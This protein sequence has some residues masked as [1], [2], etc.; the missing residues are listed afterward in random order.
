[1]NFEDSARGELV[2][3]EEQVEAIRAI[4]AAVPELV[5]NARV[6]VFLTGGDDVDEA[7]RRA[8][9]YLEAGADCTYP[10]SETPEP[11]AELTRRIDGPVNVVL[12][13]GI[14]HPRELEKL[15]VARV[16]W[17]GRLAAYA[18]AEAERIAADGL[19]S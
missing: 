12:E 7:V 13:D 16:T 3:L 5:L 17:G 4:K 1:M 11:I 19:S 15:G 9:A 14:P 6:D 18:Y 8:N 2:P 10:Y